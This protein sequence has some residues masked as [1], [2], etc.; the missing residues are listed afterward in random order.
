VTAAWYLEAQ[1][2]IDEANRPK[3]KGYP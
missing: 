1:A 2:L 3:G